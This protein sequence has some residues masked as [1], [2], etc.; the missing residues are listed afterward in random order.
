MPHPSS[1]GPPHKP[2]PATPAPSIMSKVG[3]MARGR[4]ELSRPRVS[5]SLRATSTRAS[6]GATCHIFAPSNAPR[7]P[8]L[9]CKA[10][11]HGERAVGGLEAGA[12]TAAATGPGLDGGREWRRRRRR[13]RRWRRRVGFLI[14]APRPSS[15]RG[16]ELRALLFHEFASSLLFFRSPS[17]RGRRSR[18]HTTPLPPAP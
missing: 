18:R 6:G 8:G 7:P 1:P 14:S 10:R 4:R 11:E 9:R 16:F 3:K 13:R 17:V 5:L 2:P 12:R 15:T